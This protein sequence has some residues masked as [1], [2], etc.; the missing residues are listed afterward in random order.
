[1]D[2][3]LLERAGA[4]EDSQDSGVAW[5][6][7]DLS[8]EQWQ[9]EK[10]DAFSDLSDTGVVTVSGPDR[11]SWLT[12]ISSQ[13][14]NPMG[15]DESKELLLLD[16]NGRISFAAGVLDDG[17]KT[18][19]L[20][21]GSRTQALLDFLN[22]MKFMLRV[23]MADETPSVAVVG[24]VVPVSKVD[25]A[26]EDAAGLHGFMKTWVDP[27]PG[28]VEGGA[29]YT[30]KDLKEHPASKR[31]RLLHL[32]ERDRLTEFADAWDAKGGTWAGRNAW[33]A[34]RIED[35]R[36][37]WGREVD[38]KSVPHE[39]D[40][41]RTAVHL[42]KGCYSGQESVARIVNMGKPP[43]RLVLLQLDGS[44][45]RVVKP[46]DDVEA[47]GRRVGAITTVARHADW[48]PIA[49]AVIR[50]GIALDLDLDVVTEDGPIA[51]AQ[52]VI[53]DPEGK[54]SESPENRPGADLRKARRGVEG[55]PP[56]GGMGLKK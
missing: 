42:H 43:R 27:W 2:S 18:T 3:P 29:T 50:R 23:E 32:V 35:F 38:E 53:V 25:K 47:K 30:P 22:S 13:I 8:E 7:G 33:E 52:E 1:M 45:T 11:L 20:V 6:Y 10:G 28:V 15:V 44:Q 49:L 51:A 4:V 48:G 39:L 37:R 9:L 5:H 24:Q 40:W 12:T 21:E 34:L 36:P 56:I 31:R 54:S 19:L 16:P 55:H 46:G 41:I 14:V 17:E 26:L